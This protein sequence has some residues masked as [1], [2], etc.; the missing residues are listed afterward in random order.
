MR[1]RRFVLMGSGVAV[2]AL[3]FGVM[4]V[5]AS[6]AAPLKPAA[7]AHAK[8]PFNNYKNSLKGNTNGWCNG[9]GSEPCDGNYYGTIDIV[10]H[11]YTNGG[12][13][14][15][16]VAVAGP[17]GANKYARVTGGGPGFGGYQTNVNGCP[18]PGSE[19]CTGP[20]TT[21]GNPV[22]PNVFPTRTGFTTSI[23]IYLDPTW[24]A[25]NPGQVIDWDTALGTS[26]G[27][28]LSDFAFNMCTT[29]A[30][31]GGFYISFG[32]GAG[33]CSTGP[34]ELTQS[35]WY[36]FNEQFVSVG[37][38]LVEDGNV[39]SPS[40]VS[41]FTNTDN[42]GDAITGVGGPIYGWLPDEDVNGLPLAN[43]SL[44]Q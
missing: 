7:I 10:K 42:T 15:Y 34:T 39:L 12:G 29:A 41:L 8:K 30:G 1:I 14:N 6:G 13:A 4:A 31:G 19:N 20:Y 44:K 24:A 32:N 26:T 35:G 9:A 28:F 5:P 25:A 40:N 23:Q 3:A 18:V 17:N 2:A 22:A 33:G 37:G 16:A 43:V 21:W 11:T 38:S 36:T 27:G